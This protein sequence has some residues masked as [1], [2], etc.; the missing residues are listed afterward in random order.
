MNLTR[1]AYNKVARGL[2]VLLLISSLMVCMQWGG[3]NQVYLFQAEVDI[4]AKLFTHPASVMHP[5]VI[6]PLVGQ[7]L[8]FISL[9]Q[10]KPSVWLTIPAVKGIGLLVG[11]IFVVGCIASQTWQI[12]CAIPALLCCICIWVWIVIGFLNKQ[13]MSV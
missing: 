13:K 6:L 4:L 5:L 7:I 8:L 1:S 2:N 9:F 12:L 10:K 11:F 3:N